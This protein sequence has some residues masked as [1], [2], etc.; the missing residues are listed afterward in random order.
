[1]TPAPAP[2]RDVPVLFASRSL[3]LFAYGLVSVVLVLHLSAAGYGERR[4]GAL[5]TLTLLGDTALSLWITTHADR[6]GRRRML[7]A[8]AA[9]MALAGAVF[10]ATTSF[11]LLLLAATVG[12][13]SP[14][15]NEVGPFLAVEQAALSQELPAERRTSA[16]AWYQLAGAAATALG[17]LAGGALAGALQARGVAPLASYRAV[18]AGYGVAGLALAAVFTRLSP[19]VEAPTAPA[20][21]RRSR[22][23]LHRSRDTVLRL[24]ALFSVDAFAG[25]FVVQSFVAWW[26]HARFGVGP[27][28][29]G[30]IFFGAN[31]LA[32]ISALSAAWIARRIGL[33]NTMVLTH[34]PSNV[35][36]VLV[37]LMPTLPLA[38]AVLLV[39]FSI[40]QMDVPTR[41]S[42]TMAVVE[43]DERSAAAG[44]TGIARTIGAAL[45]PL[46]AGP[47][48]ASAALASVPFF[49]SGGLKILYDLALWRSFRRVVPDE[50]RAGGGAPSARR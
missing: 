2:R 45:A 12:V 48:Y 15:G 19:A 28:T 11:A 10:A 17:A 4:I 41:Q 1:M 25:G 26:F 32:G 43:P 44:V 47:L 14:S 50:E 5:L 33:V 7:V 39:R 37:P 34:L 35:L 6:W 9:L 22:L 36:L 38:I 3:R 8:G 13:V 18:M 27:A 21:P 24:S 20:A 30:A 40:S 16:F 31:L 42:Y 46:A 49:V 29:L 23:G